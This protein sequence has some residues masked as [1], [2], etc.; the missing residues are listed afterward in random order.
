MEQFKWTFE[1]ENLGTK[2]GEIIELDP[3]V[4][5]CQFAL[6]LKALG[7][8]EEEYGKP[9]MN[10]VF[11]GSGNDIDDQN[12]EL[13]SPEFIRA[14]ACSTYI[15]IDNNQVYQ[16]EATRDEFK[17]LEIYQ[18]CANDLMFI[19]ELVKAATKAIVEKVKNNLNEEGTPKRKN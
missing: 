11:G 6:T 9:L 2:D 18:S 12:T 17:N 14:L 15:K 16:N 10:V 1:K 7:M 8:F 4:Y 19:G 5:H 3:T 13:G